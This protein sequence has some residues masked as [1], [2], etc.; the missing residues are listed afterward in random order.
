MLYH[1]QS[2]LK[3]GLIVR[4]VAYEET[5]IPSAIRSHA[6]FE[7][8]PL[9][10]PGLSSR[11]KL[12]RPL[13]ILYSLMRLSR[14]YLVLCWLL[15]WKIPSSDQLLAQNPPALP[16]LPIAHLASRLKRMH[17]VI[18]WHNFS[19]S[20]LA[21]K[22][23][24]D[25]V[26]VRM[27]RKLEHVYAKRA[28]QH[29]C[30]SHAMQTHLEET[31]HLQKVTCFFDHLPEE[32]LPPANG[33]IALP[34]PLD[35]L[36]ADD[37]VIV[38]SSSWTQDEDFSLLL[39]A[40]KKYDRASPARHLHVVLTGKG[41]G[42]AAFEEELNSLKFES[43]SVITVWLNQASY[44]ALL[45]RADLGICVHTSSSG[46]D[47]PM[48]IADMLGVGLPVCAYEYSETIKE[49]IQPDNGA[50][51]QNG[52][53]LGELLL[54]FFDTDPA[55]LTRRKNFCA[56]QRPPNW[57][58]HWEGRVLPLIEQQRD[59][60][61]MVHPVLGFG[62]AERWLTDTATALSEAGYPVTLWTGHISNTDYADQMRQRGVEIHSLQ[63]EKIF[64]LLKDRHLLRSCVLTARIAW[65]LFWKRKSVQTLI[66]DTV[67]HTLP[68]F[69]RGL[70]K[71]K[72]YYGHFPDQ[73]L[74][75]E[76][77]GKCYA[78]YRRVMN[79]IELHGL[80]NADH[81]LVNSAFTQSQFARCYP[82]I[83]TEVVTPGIETHRWHAIPPLSES[84]D[85]P[86]FHRFLVVSRIHP[87]KNIAL[88]VEAFDHFL[89]RHPEQVSN[90]QLIIAGGYDA[91][92]QNQQNTLDALKK[93]ID[94]CGRSDQIRFS[95]N[96][97]EEA[98]FD[99]YSQA[100]VVL[101]PPEYEH[102]GLVPL[103]AM[104]A[105]RPV[106]ASKHGGPAESVLHETTGLLVPPTAACFSEAI[107]K[108]AF[109]AGLAAQYGLAGRAHV[110][111][112]FDRKTQSLSLLRSD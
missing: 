109:T 13:F 89:S 56:T 52:E 77:D 24:P 6:Q 58:S 71:Q 28:D 84:S 88:A 48:K 112:R 12:P 45:Q 43:V 66:M 36:S 51:F 75:P 103:E 18:D 32:N 31:L 3:A 4:A 55:A 25:H 47:L 65:R 34:P 74:A 87:D 15:C 85:Q 30:V 23:G 99:L 21:M 63:S 54:Q 69:T 35:T 50:L 95:L 80:K 97:S 90:T 7:F 53:E 20:I 92:N 105:A 108:L 62:G 72:I 73:L 60:I 17:W 102:F 100:R 104:A 110:S 64:S 46:L 70:A 57:Q 93:Q 8:Y 9:A 59:A 83:S 81:V 96:C 27:M 2:L 98:L 16:T 40:L 14:Q 61:L 79:A 33:D 68:L 26:F 22:L 29:L 11:H 101:Y 67:P 41:V 91:D 82:S 76:R 38:S 10:A 94:A 42:R 107:S 86:E 49:Q 5:A 78:L 19:D 39:D 111:A 106:I 44:F 1:I 37:A